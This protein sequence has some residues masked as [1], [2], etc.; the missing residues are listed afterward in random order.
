MK[1]LPVLMRNVPHQGRRFFKN[2][3]RQGGPYFQKPTIGRGLAIGDLDNDG[4]P[5][6]VISHNNTSVVLLRNEAAAGPEQRWI[7]FK[8]NGRKARDLVG[9]TVILD[10]GTRTLTR[11]VKGSGSYLSA[12]DPRI[13][14]GLGPTG[15]C[16][17]L[18]IRWS[19]GDSQHW[20]NLEHN[21]YWDLHEGQP[22]ATPQPSKK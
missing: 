21:R 9:T 18:T 6:L 12:G 17:G 4:W 7:G 16:K 15:V 13:L 3:T 10:D 14:F 22:A 1:Q 5:D 11:Y 19:W 20:D 8:L 2:A